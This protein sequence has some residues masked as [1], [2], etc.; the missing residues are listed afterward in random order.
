MARAS[1]PATRSPS[2]WWWLLLLVPC[3]F[4]GWALGELDIPKPR[5][6]KAAAWPGGVPVPARVESP[7]AG[8]AEAQPPARETPREEYSQW[9]TLENALAESQRNGKPVLIDFSA[10]WCGPCRM[11]KREVFDDGTHGRIVQ[12]AVIPVS[13][14]DRVRE[15][16]R[17]PPEIDDLK[18]RYQVEAFPTLVVFSPRSGRTMKTRGFGGAEWTVTWITEAAR[19]VR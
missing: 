1:T 18:Q 2:P 8:A 15:D 5:E 17:N 14:V 9:T 10:D 19:E 11:L 7:G 3:P 16:G 13:I 6:P 4:V 12:T